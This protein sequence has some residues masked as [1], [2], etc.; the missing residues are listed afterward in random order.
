MSNRDQESAM[1]RSIVSVAKM[2][3]NSRW[4]RAA[5]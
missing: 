2:P 1:K 3:S 4:S 5:A